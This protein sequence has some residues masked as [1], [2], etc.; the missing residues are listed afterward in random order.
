MGSEQRNRG[1]VF[2]YFSVDTAIRVNNIRQFRYF[3]E[4]RSRER[5]LRR[6]GFTDHATHALL[7]ANYAVVEKKPSPLQSGRRLYAH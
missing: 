4:S 7:Y 2:R 6:E 1:M 3:M 5:R